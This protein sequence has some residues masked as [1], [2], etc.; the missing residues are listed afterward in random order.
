MH[1]FYIDEWVCDEEKDSG[2]SSDEKAPCDD[3][4]EEKING[5]YF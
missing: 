4:I 1:N 5:K 3:Q 2:V